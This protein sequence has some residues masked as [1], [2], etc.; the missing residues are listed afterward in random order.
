ML[1][2]G[3]PFSDVKPEAPPI[4]AE[5]APTAFIVAAILLAIAVGGYIALRIAWHKT[6]M[7][8]EHGWGALPDAVKI[9]LKLSA[10]VGVGAL[11]LG[12]LFSM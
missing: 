9:P 5:Y 4:V 10:I 2:A 1:L 7:D 12:L 6:Q 3:S 8:P 11:L